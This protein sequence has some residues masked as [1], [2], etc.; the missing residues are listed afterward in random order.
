M[1]STRSDDSPPRTGSQ[2][3]RSTIY[4]VFIVTVLA[5]AAVFVISH[6]QAFQAAVLQ[7]KLQG[8]GP[9]APL[10]FILAYAAATVAFVPGS[11]FTLAGGAL[12]GPWWGTAWNLVG[13]SLG[14][15]LA[16]LT[17][18]YLAFDWVGNKGGE[19]LG[20]VMHGVEAEGWRFVA[21]VR[22]VPLFPFNLLNYALGLTRIGFATYVLTSVVCMIPGVFAYTWLGFAGRQALTGDEKVLRDALIA[23]G[24]MAA[25]MLLPRLVKRFRAPPNF[26]NGSRM[27]DRLGHEPEKR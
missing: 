2:S 8:F 18:R 16:F 27:R 21:L 24:A 17:A 26:V 3:Y 23:L 6:R 25:V 13:A 1:N 22:L 9:L 14:A 10:L 11:A 5:V 20:R 4:R 7:Q 12:F 19:G 15:A